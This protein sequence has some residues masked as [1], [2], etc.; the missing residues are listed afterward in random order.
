MRDPRI[1]A[2]AH[3]AAGKSGSQ[4]ATCPECKGAV[5]VAMVAGESVMLET[6]LIVVAAYDPRVRPG[7]D[8]REREWVTGHRRHAAVCDERR[9]EIEKAKLR[10]EMQEWKRGQ[11]T[12]GM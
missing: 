12:R 7:R 9:R 5:I 2:I 3:L 1:P 11:R 4:K 10:R 6:E 8:R